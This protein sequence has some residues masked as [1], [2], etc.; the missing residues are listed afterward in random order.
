MKS[1]QFVSQRGAIRLRADVERKRMFGLQP[2]D[3]PTTEAR[4][5]MYS[6]EST[7]KTYALLMSTAEEILS[8]GYSVIIDATFLKLN[9]RRA[10]RD[11]A[12]RLGIEF[13][14]LDCNATDDVLR[15]RVRDRQASEQDAS[16]ADP[17]VLEHQLANR[18][19]LTND[20][21]V[22]SIQFNDLLQ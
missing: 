21:R 9:Q 6:Q 22:V 19:P 8:A 4:Q 18:E 12:S 17:G 5:D 15:Q 3:R 7:A 1:L 16:D 10:A 20:E 11:L 14:I 13:N 2:L